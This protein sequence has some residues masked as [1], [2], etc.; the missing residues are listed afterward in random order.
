MAYDMRFLH[1]KNCLGKPFRDEKTGNRIEYCPH[2][3]ILCPEFGTDSDSHAEFIPL[4][5]K[6]FEGFNGVCR[7]CG[8]AVYIT[9][10]NVVK[11]HEAQN[12]AIEEALKDVVEE[13]K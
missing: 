5:R 2:A 7:W 9:A 6:T 8:D 12:K 13:S 3:F 1:A 4:E 10:E 11:D